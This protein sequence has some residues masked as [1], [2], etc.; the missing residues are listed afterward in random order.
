[1]CKSKGGKESCALT[2]QGFG[3]AAECL[4]NSSDEVLETV[5]GKSDKCV[6]F[7]EL[8]IYVAFFLRVVPKRF[9]TRCRA[10]E[11]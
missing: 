1:M 9:S 2:F 5:Q 3:T 7:D 8:E 6:F 10:E 11:N 4:M